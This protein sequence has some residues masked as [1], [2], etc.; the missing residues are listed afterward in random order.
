MSISVTVSEEGSTSVVSTQALSDTVLI[1][2]VDLSDL[3]SATGVLDTRVNA[4]ESD[5]TTVSGLITSNDSDISA[6]QT[7]TG[8][9]VQKSETGNFVIDSETGAFYATSNPSGFITGVDLSDLNTATGVLNTNVNALQA[10][11]G[12]F[13]QTGSA[14]FA[15]LN[16]TGRVGIGT[17]SPDSTL[18]LSSS[19]P[20]ILTIEADTDNVTE[21]DNARIVFKQDGGAVIGRIGYKSNT[22]S[23][24][25]INQFPEKLSLGTNNTERLLINS[26]GNVG[27]GTT[28]PAAK[29]HVGGNTI[30]SGNL[31]I[32]GSITPAKDVAFDIGSPTKRFKDLYLSGDSIFLGE[33]KLSVSG[34]ELQT[35]KDGVVKRFIKNTDT[36]NFAPLTLVNAK[37]N[38]T[39]PDFTGDNT[40]FRGNS[41]FFK[42]VAINGNVGIGTTAPAAKLHVV[43]DVIVSGNSSFQNRPTVNGTG[44]LLS[45]EG[46]GGTIE[47]VVFTTGDQEIS[48]VKNFS[49]TIKAAKITLSQNSFVTETGNF[50]LGATHKGAT[51]FLQNSSPITITAPAQ[52]AGYVTTFIAETQNTVSFATGSGISGLNS[53]AGASDMAGIFAQAQII[54]KSSSGAFL[55]G[56]I[57]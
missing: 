16:V 1:T 43:G 25:F 50:T 30:L 10:V 47:N 9:L 53:F 57:V 4:N 22:N 15:L 19:G 13:A 29:L 48:G 12:S 35:A 39:N 6:L 2:G 24:E 5:I 26:D 28:S 51:V 46:G 8:L 32:S 37:P 3:Q 34:D 54:Y 36:G 41:R 56:N 21:T 7:A 17:T 31:D 40:F 20:T 42:T 33:T 27:I 49:Q 23:L 18:H 52:T 11:S 45:G 55:G 14:T 38:A 44:V